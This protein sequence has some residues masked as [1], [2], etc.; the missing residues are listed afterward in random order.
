MS[1]FQC[2]IWKADDGISVGI[3]AEPKG[4]SRRLLVGSCWAETG[5]T[6]STAY[7]GVK[8]RR[9]RGA[10]VTHVTVV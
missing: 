2:G 5:R 7:L 10:L 3:R 9:R 8:T 4:Q 6:Q 1:F